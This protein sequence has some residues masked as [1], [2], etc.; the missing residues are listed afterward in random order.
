MTI[1]EAISRVFEGLN[2][3]S[4]DSTIRKRFVLSVLK[5]VRSELIRQE[6]NKNSLWSSASAQILSPI[7]ARLD[8][9]SE[10]KDYKA[11]TLVYKSCIK[12]PE[13]VDTKYGKVIQGVY[14]NNG[15]RLDLIE[16]ADYE[17]SRKVRHSLKRCK[18]FIRNRHLYIINYIGGE[19]I[20]VYMEAIFNDPELI[21]R[22]NP[23]NANMYIGNMQFY[24]PS[25]LE[26]RLFDMAIYEVGRK[27]GIRAD[28]INNSRDDAG[29]PPLQQPQQ[30]TNS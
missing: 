16:Y 1:E 4:D 26:R 27:Y 29:V 23:D 10:S 28:T 6:T 12:I 24:C 20:E 22:M 30:T 21:E 14:F 2:V 8:T 11:S 5:S 7:C 19:E 25:Y 17:G 13:I 9:I 3:S 18:C 15:S